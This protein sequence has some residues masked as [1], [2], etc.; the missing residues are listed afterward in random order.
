MFDVVKTEAVPANL[1]F[2]EPADAVCFEFQERR[3]DNLP[4]VEE[5]VQYAQEMLG[6]RE[7]E[8]RRLAKE[9]LQRLRSEVPRV[10]IDTPAKRDRAAKLGSSGAQ[11]LTAKDL[12]VA[13]STALK[14]LEQLISTLGVPKQQQ[15]LPVQ[16]V[17]A[18]ARAGDN[19][20][21]KAGVRLFGSGT[22]ESLSPEEAVRRA[23][24]AAGRPREV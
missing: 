16:P 11:A 15:E 10:E 5:L 6:D 9:E 7:P 22:Q 20:P 8:L 17:T 12:T 24:A 19:S 13:M 3:A 2:Q 21:L 14:P 23:A 1:P 18:A 4:P